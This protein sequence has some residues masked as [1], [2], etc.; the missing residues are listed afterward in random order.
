MQTVSLS[1]LQGIRVS[2]E[3]QSVHALHAALLTSFEN[4]PAPQGTHSPV[5][6]TAKEVPHGGVGSIP[7]G[8]RGQEMH[9]TLLFSFIVYVS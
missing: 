7:S 2:L 1:V 5:N 3:P 4:D 8:H 9:L 6:F